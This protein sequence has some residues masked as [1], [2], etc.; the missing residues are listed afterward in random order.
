MPATA[1]A[2]PCRARTVPAPRPSRAAPPSV[3]VRPRPLRAPPPTPPP[4]PNARPIRRVTTSNAPK[5][6]DRWSSIVGCVLPAASRVVSPVAEPPA[7]SSGNGRAALENRRESSRRVSHADSSGIAGPP[8]T[9]LHP[10]RRSDPYK[11]QE[12]RPGDDGEDVGAI[13]VCTATRRRW[14]HQRAADVSGDERRRRAKRS[15]GRLERAR[16][17]VRGDAGEKT[18]AEEVRKAEADL[19]EASRPSKR[20][21][22]KKFSE[23]GQKVQERV[24][25]EE[26]RRIRRTGG[27][28]S[29]RRARRV[30]G[31][32]PAPSPGESDS[33]SEGEIPL[34]AFFE[35]GA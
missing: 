35:R 30:G 4:P 33:E 9:Q 10:V 17:G 23:E 25:K 11:S 22:E 5:V 6:S 34:K 2:C 32:R 16:A 13:R 12:G 29:R 7:R 18:A 24:K 21:E 19:A 1:D 26:A 8:L 20:A 31:T 15:G 3:P 14:G 27:I 28:R